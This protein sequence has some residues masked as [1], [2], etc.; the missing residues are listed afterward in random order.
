MKLKLF[1]N[2]IRDYFFLITMFFIFAA[3]AT[4]QKRVS[5]TVSSNGLPLPG[6]NVLVKGTTIGVS[7][8]LD[9]KF[10]MDVPESAQTLVVSYLGYLTQEVPISSSPISVNLVEESNKLEEVVVNVGYGTQKKSVVTGSISKVG[11]KDLEKVPNGRIEQSLQGRTAGVTIA[12]NAGQP[13]SS[14]TVR[15]RGI[16]TFDTYGG[17]N[18][19]WVVDGVVVDNGALGAVN[20]SDIESIEVLKDAASL[21]IYGSRSA[22]GVVLITTKKGKKGKFTTTYNGSFAVSSP[23]RTIKLLNAPQYAAI[24]NEKAVNAGQTPPYSN[25]NEYGMGTDWQ[26]AIFSNSA[27]TNAHEVSISGANETSNIYLSFGSKYQEGIVLPEISTWDRK[28]IRLNGSHKVKDWLTI[29]HTFGYTHQKLVG[30]GNTNSEFGGPLSSAINLDPITPLIDTDPT[31]SGYYPQYAIRDENGNPYGISVGYPTTVG[32]EMTNPLAYTKTVL[33]NHGWSDDFI[34]NV[35]GEVTIAKHFK[36][37]SSLGGKLAFWGA[38]GF[39]PKYYLSATVNNLVNNRLTRRNNRALDWNIENTATYSNQFGSHNLS[40]L[41]GQ[42]AYIEG[43]IWTETS[44][45]HSGLSTNNYQDASFNDGSVTAT[46][47]VG[48]SFDGDIFK[49]TSLFARVNY[50]YKE[51]YLFTGAIRR[52]GSDRFGGNNKYGIFPAFSMG[53]VVT[54]EEFWKPNK[55]INTLKLRAGYGVNGN[56]RIPLGAYLATIGGERNYT[57]GGGTAV[58]PG[59]SPGRIANPDLKWEETR[60]TDIGFET[61]LFDNLNLNF[62]WYKKSTVGILREN[63][64]PGYVGAELPP[65]ANIADMDN[66]GI[67]IELGYKKKIHSFNISA[68]ANFATLKNEVTNLGQG[69]PYISGNAAFQSMG[70]ITRTQVG[71]AYNSF[72]GFQTAGVFQNYDEIN[73]YTNSTGGLIQPDAVPGDFRWTDTNGDGQIND[74]DKVFLG[75]PLPKY[76]FGLTFNVDYKGFDLMVFTQGAAGNKIFQGLRRLDV[77]NSN[78]QTEALSRWHGEGTSYDYPRLTNSDTNGNFSRMSDFYLEKGDYLRLK[79]VQFGYTL[80]TDVT[81]K[82]GI[83]KLRFYVT[84]ENLYTFTKYT[85]YDPEIGGNVF[86]VDKGYYPQAR[87]I[88]FGAN[89]QF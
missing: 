3:V 74:N 42:G 89:I 27:T 66:K 36:F 13:G 83:N 9:G 54:K 73:A 45:T 20:Q 29:G 37:K 85:G 62:D 10:A 79:I 68:N 7:T 40:V 77:Q 78:Y 17:N 21:A 23:E 58:S 47:K 63:P 81:G 64:I 41:L 49:L 5:G 30:I 22:S 76:T 24:M 55:V 75:S 50:D 4:A 46:N 14:A 60:Q 53:W 35:N 44:V 48:Y 84:G 34:G 32:Q 88:I 2:R 8:D 82:V 72:Y 39:T 1:A 43:Q 71:E 56:S 59:S 65:I 26:K 11:A 38:E 19:L 28:N 80:P 18:P 86:G 25:I 33:G 31:R 16:T 57:L 51:K 67:E 12:M 61:R 69:I 15:V 87:S 52:D 70:A 6:A